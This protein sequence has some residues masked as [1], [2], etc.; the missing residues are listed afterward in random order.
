LRLEDVGR[1]TVSIAKVRPFLC[2]LDWR[3]VTLTD[4]ADLRTLLAPKT[5]QLE[6]FAA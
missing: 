1:L 5:E 4:R 6:L 2:A 3:P